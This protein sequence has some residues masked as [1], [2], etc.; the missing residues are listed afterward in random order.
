M[1]KNGIYIHI[2]FCVKKCNY[3]D[4]NSFCASDTVQDIYTDALVNEIKSFGKIKKIDA[5]SVFF[6]GGT[7]TL[8]KEENL[9]KIISAIKASINLMPDTEFTV[10]CNPKTANLRKLKHL[11][12]LGVNRLSLGVQSLDD[13]ILKTLGRAHDLK[14]F[15]ECFAAARI[16]GFE[17]IS[18]DLMFALPDQTEKIW[19]TTLENAIKFEPKHISAYGLQ[20]EEGTLFYENQANYKFPDDEQNRKMYEFLVEFL[21]SKGYERYEISNFAIPGFESRHNLKYWD[22]TE[23]VGFGLGSSS[24]FEGVRYQNPEKM[25]EYLEF[26]DNFHPLWENAEKETENSLISEYMFLGLRLEKGVNNLEFKEKFNKSFFEIYKKE[27]DQNVN[28]GLL[29]KEN[30]RIYLSKKGFDLANS[31]M[32]DFLLED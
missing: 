24:F 1:R 23:Y 6:G 16:A 3:C 17:N 28:N 5:D 9:E 8:L 30:N 31:V 20:L 25:E 2:P 4:F 11:F 14:D 21:K 18:F 10:E 22:L 27:I 7:P 32:S 26:A 15:I 29:I 19:Q 13:K 12:D